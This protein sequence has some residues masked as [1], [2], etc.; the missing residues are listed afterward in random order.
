MGK[1]KADEIVKQVESN[2]DSWYKKNASR[3]KLM[4]DL[5]LDCAACK[6]KE[7]KDLIEKEI[8]LSIKNLKIDLGKLNKQN[9]DLFKDVEKSEKQDIGKKAKEAVDKMLT[10]YKKGS[11]T[12]QLNG[13][14]KDGVPTVGVSGSF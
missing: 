12:V 14:M 2:L 3:I 13:D 11:K 10:V 9:G 7:A 4:D 8:D 6:T 1:P 5:T